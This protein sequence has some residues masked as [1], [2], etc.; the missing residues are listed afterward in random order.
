MLRLKFLASVLPL[1]AAGLFAGR[2]LVADVHP[3][4]STVAAPV[5]LTQLPWQATRMVSF[6][7][8]PGEATVRVQIVDDPALADFTVVDG[9]APLD[10]DVCT[11]AGPTRFIGIDQAAPAPTVI[12]LTRDTNADYRIYVH[13]H[14]FS[15]REAA[16]L[17][18]G[19]HSDPHEV[20]TGSL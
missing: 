16:A 5:E 10:S 18:V 7:S 13:S 14:S 11:G 8:D 3:C 12:Y 9:D 19:A 2:Q 4:I 1:V 6:T 20:A 17:I 15:M